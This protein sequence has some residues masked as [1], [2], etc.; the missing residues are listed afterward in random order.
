M[1]CIILAAGF[2][3]RLYPLT[4]NFPKSLLPIK[5]R[6]LLDYLIED[7]LK[8]KEITHIT[9]ITNNKFYSLF[10]K[11]VQNAFPEVNVS[12]LNNGVLNET[13]KNGAIQDLSYVLSTEKIEDDILIL[14]SDTYTSLK[15]QDFIRF[16]RQFKSITTAVFDGKDVEKIRNKLGCV[17]VEKNKITQFIEKP[18]EPPST[19]MA[20]PFYIIPRQYIP[21]ISTYLEGNNTDAPGRFISW[22]VKEHIVYAFNIGTGYY[23]DIGTNE[24]YEKIKSF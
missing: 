21:L 12:V 3:T 16:Y 20:I 5:G 10:K 2:A 13:Q 8:Q 23:Y 4:H 22:A 17:I 19:L 18:S 24:Q 9:L 6:A 1:H 11:H 15:L 7:V 14:A